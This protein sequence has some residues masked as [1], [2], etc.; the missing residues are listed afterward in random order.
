LSSF[1][2]FALPLLVFGAVLMR[3]VKRQPRSN[4][5]EDWPVTE[6]TIQSTSKVA[7]SAGRGSYTIDVCDFS[8][9]V[10]DE[11]HSGRLA[12]SR[13]NDGRL[14][15]SRPFESETVPR[16]LVDQKIQVRYNPRNPDSYSVPPSELKGFL[17]DPFD[18]TMASDIGP[19]DLNLG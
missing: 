10:N 4:P 17:L 12:L 13:P 5:A 19:I 9:I 16:D 1:V 15:V 11:Y 3:L 8:Y 18:E 6:A 14:A 7:I 2:A